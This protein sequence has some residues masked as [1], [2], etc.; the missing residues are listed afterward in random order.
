MKIFKE[1]SLIL[2]IP[3]LK[4]NKYLILRKSTIWDA[5]QIIEYLNCVGGESDYLLFGKD[6]FF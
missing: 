1:G 6:E 4:N 3:K 5:K 2:K